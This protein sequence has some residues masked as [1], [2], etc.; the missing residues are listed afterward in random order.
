MRL[1]VSVPTGTVLA[2][3]AAKVVA[4][5]AE[6]SIG[7]LPRHVD[8]VAVLVP[9]LLVYETP[10]DEEVYLAVD[11]GLLVK[12]G[13]RILVSVRDAVRGDELG[14]LRRAVRDRFE[15]LDDRER[16]ARTALAR[17][18]ARFIRQFLQ[19]AEGLRDRR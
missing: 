7:I 2:D 13:D 3:E 11:R 8:Y 17:L 4:E 19:Q 12:R 15:S 1:R 6:G 18:E 10:S 5:A 9:G 16:A 14:T